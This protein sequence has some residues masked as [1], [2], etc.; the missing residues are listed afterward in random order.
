MNDLILSVVVLFGI[1][2]IL[3]VTDKVMTPIIRERESEW[4][5]DLD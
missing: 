3:A 4:Y 2:G 1:I 5:R